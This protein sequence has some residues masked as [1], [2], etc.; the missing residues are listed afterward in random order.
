MDALLSR[1]LCVTHSMCNKSVDM[2]D[3]QKA[4]QRPHV[5]RCFAKRVWIC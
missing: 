5:P 1:K 2:V 3:F 4:E